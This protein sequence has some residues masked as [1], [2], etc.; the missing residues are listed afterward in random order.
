MMVYDG[1]G[2]PGELTYNAANL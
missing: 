2:F 1:K